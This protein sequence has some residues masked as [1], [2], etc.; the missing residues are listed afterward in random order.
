MQAKRR[1]R[2]IA[3]STYQH[4]QPESS[5]ELLALLKEDTVRAIVVCLVYAECEANVSLAEAEYA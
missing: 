3:H 5:Q 2:P 1:A 4:A